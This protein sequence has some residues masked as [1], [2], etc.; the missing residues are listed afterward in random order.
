MLLSHASSRFFRRLSS[1][2]SRESRLFH[3]T[4]TSTSR[5]P[6]VL[7][8]GRK[9]ALSS[10]Y[11]IAGV[12][13]GGWWDDKYNDR[14]ITR[15]FRTAYHGILV[16]IDY[17]FNFNPD[18]IDAIDALHERAA[19]RLL[20]VCEKNRGLY[21]KLAQAL[22]TQA[23][24]LPKP[25]LKLAKLLD[26]AEHFDYKA[27]EEI[28][29]RELGA[30]ISKLFIRFD[31]TPIAAAE[32]AVKVQRPDIRRHA[33]W[34]LLAFRTLMRMYDYFFD[35]PLSFAAQYISDQIMQE[36][37]FDNE[38][39]NSE[40]IRSLVMSSRNPSIREV[41]YVPRIHDSLST[42]RVLT[43]EYISDACKLTD[44]DKIRGMGLDVGAVAKTAVEV[45]ATQIFEMGFVQTDG[46][47]S[48]VLIRRHPNGAQG[49]HQIVLIDHGLYVTLTPEFRY[50][51]CRLWTSGRA[52]DLL[53]LG[54]RASRTFRKRYTPETLAC[55]TKLN[56]DVNVFILEEFTQGGDERSELESRRELKEKL[57][58]L[59]VNVELLPRELIFIG[60]AMRILQAN[61]QAMGSPVNRINILA[62]RAA[63]GL[64]Y[65]QPSDDREFDVMTRRQT[66]AIVLYTIQ[67]YTSFLR[68]RFTLF[69][70]DVA[71]HISNI[72]TWLHNT[73]DDLKDSSEGFE[74]ELEENLRDIARTQFGMQISEDAFST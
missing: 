27:V 9:A 15:N 12:A 36:T 31:K 19:E 26:N 56:R 49:Q 51:Y 37:L 73:D 70:V 18:S 63:A 67:K 74:D 7:R 40:K 38:A 43:M 66:R 41:A 30:P 61:N 6:L 57:K 5:K 65:S 21:V 1:L 24:I 39:A 69:L 52:G 23:A 11:V 71:F 20:R 29:E 62:R 60:R 8:G 46:H 59:L 14:T 33:K 3:T 58:T 42:P 28:V 48:N 17:K 35:L 25:Y 55:K 47:P 50:K 10:A 34:D 54:D 64:L 22:G 68:F 32:V 4:F 44:L 53:G 2:S 16:A 72:L 45:F 13:L